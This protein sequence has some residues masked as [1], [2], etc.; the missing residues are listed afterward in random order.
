MPL[1]NRTAKK[2]AEE[3]L[4][5]QIDLPPEC[6]L[7]LHAYDQNVKGRLFVISYFARSIRQNIRVVE[8]YVLDDRS[9]QVRSDQRY[10]ITQELGRANE[11][12]FFRAMGVRTDET[13][14]WFRKVKPAPKVFDKCGID[15]FAFVGFQE[16]E[17][18]LR[19]PVQI[20]S[21]R[22]GEEKYLQIHTL[23]KE[24]GVVVVVI[25]PQAT[26]RQLRQQVYDQLAETRAKKM[27]N[28]T[29]FTELHTLLM[30]GYR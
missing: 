1:I 12:R 20:K 18:R 9:V 25:N 15:A 30:S 23:C 4:N 5:G 10:R 8:F 14:D 26:D 27:E 3:W 19:I 24:H 29:R 11:L 16:G 6:S 21:S 13:P 22:A 2:I 28:G 17:R 7:S